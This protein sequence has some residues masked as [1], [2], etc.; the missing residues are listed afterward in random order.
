MAA[1]VMPRAALPADAPA[2]AHVY[3]ESW[4]TTYRGRLPD[5]YLDTMD[6]GDYTERWA[7][8]LSDPK[9]R[10]IVLVAEEDDRVVGFASCGRD[11][12]ADTRHQGELYAIYLLREA[13]GR[14]HGR[15]L[16]ERSAAALAE[17]SITSMVVWVLRDNAPARGFYERMGG[18]RLRER[19]LDLG[20]GIGAIEVAY[21]WT[22]LR[23]GLIPDR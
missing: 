22:D 11:R 23:A 9:R 16:I 3:V 17:R 1:A 12:D 6:V 4:R 15:A 21:L 13:Q 18:V 20:A 10:S 8:T 5:A 14:G 2:I 19:P 7:L